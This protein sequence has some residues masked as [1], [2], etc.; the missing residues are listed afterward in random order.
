MYML[1][2][3]LF[4]VRYIGWSGEKRTVVYCHYCR[5]N[6]SATCRIRCDDPACNGSPSAPTS[7]KE[8]TESTD[9][10]ET[11]PVG[12]NN[13]EVSPTETC[14]DCFCAGA[15]LLPHR[16]DHPYRVVDCLDFP[17]FNKDWS[18]RE[19]LLLLEGI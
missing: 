13:A 4:N 10:S 11:N 7:N 12:P 18:A 1:Y 17:I 15:A 5:R 9:P 2:F 16:P 19:E 14:I 3:P 8:P 6:I